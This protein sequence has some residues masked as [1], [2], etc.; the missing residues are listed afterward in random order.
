[1]HKTNSFK[2]RSSSSNCHPAAQRSFS[3]PAINVKVNNLDEFVT[4]RSHNE[5]H[6]PPPWLIW[7]RKY[8]TSP[9]PHDLHDALW[10]R[11]QSPHECAHEKMYNSKSR[12][13]YQRQHVKS[14]VMDSCVRRQLVWVCISNTICG[15]KKNNE[16]KQ[17]LCYLSVFTIALLFNMGKTSLISIFD[18]VVLHRR[19]KI[20]APLFLDSCSHCNANGKK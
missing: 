16:M 14:D 4:R 10:R 17:C 3:Q 19:I 12:I 13:S 18:V 11:V 15:K 9:R 8:P 5:P 6:F 2:A 7:S 20:I 1:M